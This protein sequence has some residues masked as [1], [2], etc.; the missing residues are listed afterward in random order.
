MVKA[1][2]Q[3]VLRGAKSCGFY[4]TFSNVMWHR[5]GD[6]IVIR[7]TDGEFLTILDYNKGKAA[8]QWKDTRLCR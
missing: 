2:D 6:S 7:K 4:M 5:L 3:V 1:I 8:H